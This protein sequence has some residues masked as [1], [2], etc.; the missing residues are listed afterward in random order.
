MEFSLYKRR[1]VW[2]H[3]YVI[4]TY[5]YPVAFWAG[6]Q[7]TFGEA[8]TNGCAICVFLLAL[9]Q[10]FLF[11]SS[12][13]GSKVYEIS[14]LM[15]VANAE[16]AEMIKISKKQMMNSKSKVGFAP[17]LSKV[18]VIKDKKERVKWFEFD[19]DVFY[20]NGSA[21]KKLEIKTDFSLE[22]YLAKKVGV[23]DMLTETERIICPKNEFKIEPPTFIRMFAEHAV[24]PFFVF[25][26]FCALLWM[27]D[28]YWKYSLFTFF[29]IIA[30]E[31]GM[32]F[33]RHTNIKQLR[34]LNL[35]PQKILRAANEKKE[36]VLSSDLVPGD[37]V[38]IEGAIQLPADVL[39]IKGSA[40]VNESMLSG[41][42]T[43]VHKEA[44]LNEDVNL[45]LSHHKKNILYGGTKILKVDEK[46]IECIVIRT[47]FMSEQGE[48]IKSMIASEDTVSENNYE[49]YLFILAMLVFAVISCVY[50]VRES[51]TMGK[52]LYK[53]VLECIMI[54]TNVVPPE[55][56]MELTIAVN[57][58]L[59]ELV[60]LGVY[61]L[62]PFRIP[63]AGR[64][65]VCCFDKT[66][67]L[68]ELNLQLEKVEASN[69]AMAHTIIG[70]CH[71]LVL[72]N[73]K[74]EGDPLDTCGF[75]YVKGALLTDTQISIDSKEYTV[76]KKFSFDSALKRATSIIQAD[77]SFFTVMKG[78]PETVQEFLEKVPE[79]YSRFEEFAE[80]GYRVIS[81]ATKR[82]G[83]LSKQRLS[84]LD[85]SEIESG[86]EFI[87]FAFYNS[88]LKD[89]AK[90]TISH[91]KE[92]GH[93]II[94]I[95]GD[96]E[97]TA[98]SVAK[99]VGLYNEK[100][101]SGSTQIEKFLDEVSLLPEK[102][103]KSV[104]WPSVLARADPDSKEKAISLLNAIGEY[105]LMCGDG[106]N[107]VGALKTAHA[108]IALLEKTKG[109]GKAV[110][111]PGNIGQ[112]MFILDEEVKVKLGDASI[113]APFT[114][115][116]GSLQSVIDVISRGRSALVSTV[117]MYKVLA[118]N[119]LLSAYT[120]SVFDT[121][122]I[123]Y[124]DFQMTAAG[125]LSAVSFTFFGKAQPLPRI[126]KEKPVAKIFSKYIVVS[127]ILQTLVH[128][129][130]FYYI[131][132]GVIEYGS[133]VMQEKFTPTLANTAMFLLG[134]ALQVTT[135]VVNYVGRP[136][137]ESLTENKKL[138]NSL[139]LSL[140]MVVLCTLEA[141]PEINKEMQ[142]VE[143]PAKMK[144]KLL[145]T[146]GANFIL[147][148][149]IEKVSF[150]LFMRR[151]ASEQIYDKNK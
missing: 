129:L 145:A 58:S 55:L 116:T 48:L 42:A 56:P 120:L 105:T 151:P 69:K 138:L 122:G 10:G 83:T 118:L 128:I 37:R 140:G 121:M 136:F 86:M 97:K 35:K 67:T 146:I 51:L 40:V 21:I 85:R 106:T 34:S 84:T 107:D 91:L 62:E 31:G 130:S 49:A 100:Y 22:R 36:E 92:S 125:I 46:G 112:S 74:V 4:P 54:L 81:L 109:K 60:G 141:I 117:Q 123:K 126:S 99:Q 1:S 131:Y 16:D 9:I 73:G 63:F 5:F 24:S 29:T 79:N 7:F 88:K 113:A 33:Q 94:M 11:L 149:G 19:N 38:I 71:S 133:I 72:L 15:K 103:K 95:T 2:S 96:N 110:A 142:F 53:I 139:L 28:E 147:C 13:W 108:G 114:S 30:F 132:L 14:K 134:S 50:V 23:S 93:K 52:T 61:C 148:Q 25:Q 78:A 32:V 20:F 104:V 101:L 150:E 59:Q 137:R 102:E 75:E 18:V 66:G 26:I 70:T 64:I 82:L 17:V 65:T 90:E 143:I 119:C 39:I 124:G 41:E 45:S 115:R 111:L 89:N 127:V 80:K 3:T 77:G 144:M 57:S 47:G 44:I 76:I 68:T 8:G 135:L 43:P 87:G 98:I 6:T 12:F 27:L